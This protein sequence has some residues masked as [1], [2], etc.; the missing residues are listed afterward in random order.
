[1][2]GFVVMAAYVSNLRASLLAIKFEKP[3]DTVQVRC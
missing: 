2:L 3:I 1:M